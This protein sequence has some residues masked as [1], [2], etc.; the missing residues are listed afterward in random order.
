MQPLYLTGAWLEFE[1]DVNENIYVR[2]DRTRKLP[3]TVLI[4]ALGYSS[5]AQILQ[6]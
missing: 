2:I 4:R 6:L 3:A 1:T 5:N